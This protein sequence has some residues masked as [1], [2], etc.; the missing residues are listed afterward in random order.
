[1]YARLSVDFR[2]HYPAQEEQTMF[3]YTMSAN[4][5]ACNMDL[6]STYSIGLQLAD[7]ARKVKR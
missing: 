4:Y 6:S 3:K 7:G 1:M 5:L 2:G